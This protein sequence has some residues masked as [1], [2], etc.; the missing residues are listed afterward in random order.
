MND[1]NITVIVA[2]S[3]EGPDSLVKRLLE[4]RNLAVLEC[5]DGIETVRK[6]FANRPDLIILDITLPRLN[7]Y[8]CARLLKSDPVM[9]S[10]PIIHMGSSKSPIE[11]YWSGLCRGDAY[12]QR[13]VNEVDLDET[14]HSLLQ[15]ERGKRHLFLPASMI[16]DLEDH[17]I[18]TL[19][20]NLMEQDLL[21]ANILNE[22]NM[23][24]VWGMDTR[25]LVTS[26]MAIIGSLYD[27]TLGTALLLHE[28]Q[29]EFLFYPNQKTEQK[30][31]EEIKRLIFEHLESAARHLPQPGADNA[32][33]LAARRTEGDQKRDRGGLYPHKRERPCP[34]R[35]GL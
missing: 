13:P 32:D 30:R 2:E 6:S 5:G 28:R 17:S 15:K 33:P 31:L 23:I 4:K 21:R 22:I 35:V 29:G 18:L 10:T 19:A 8:Q 26:F 24:D 14:L 7:G 9:N 3:R 11:Q 16:P 34:V 1:K 12:L 25:D 27:F 20:N